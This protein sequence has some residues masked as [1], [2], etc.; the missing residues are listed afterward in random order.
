MSCVQARVLLP[1][2]ARGALLKLVEPISFWGGIDPA[3]GAVCDPRHSAYGVHLGGRVLCLSAT[4]GSSS[5]SAV[6]LE[7]LHI[8]RGPAA[9]ILAQPDAILALGAIVAGEMGWPSIPV[10]QLPVAEQQKLTCG[11]VVSIAADGA[12]SAE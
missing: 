11:Q 9:L 1:G 3:T 2:Q 7:L 8:G 10:L 6:L 5:S 4:R 12:I